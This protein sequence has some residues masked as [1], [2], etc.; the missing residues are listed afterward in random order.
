MRN[1]CSIISLD[2]ISELGVGQLE[3]ISGF[4]ARGVYNGDVLHSATGD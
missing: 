4:P 1:L 2:W 3:L